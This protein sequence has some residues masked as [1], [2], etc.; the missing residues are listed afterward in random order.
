MRN[1]PRV[2]SLTPNMA[3]QLTDIIKTPPQFAPLTP[4]WLAKFM[5]F[6][7]VENGVYRVNRVIENTTPIDTLCGRDDPMSKEI[8]QGYI[9]YDENPREIRLNAVSAIIN[10]DTRVQDIYSDPFDQTATQVALAVEALKE[11]QES[12][13]INNPDYGLLETAASSMRIKPRRIAP[14]PDDFDDM[15]SLVWKEPSFF[16]AHPR[17][18]AAFARECT[19]R[20][21]PPEIDC[22]F[23]GKF[24]TWRGVPIVPCNKLAVDGEYNPA[25]GGGK[26]NILLVRT[27]EDKRGA[28]GLYQANV[29]NDQA[30]GLSLR[31]RGI[32]DNGVSSYLLNLYCA[33]AILS[34][35]AVAVLEDVD[36]GQYTDNR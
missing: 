5:Q 13:L 19:K 32:N 36:V 33:A 29:P 26:T 34:D 22:S 18:V 8:P 6:R 31:F 15:L 9:K 35:D 28:I 2:E 12:Q 10:V 7:A 24:L 1:V 17:A 3:Y 11:R 23:G 27:G 25:I 16:L 4:R 14:T 30:R 21:V 20:G